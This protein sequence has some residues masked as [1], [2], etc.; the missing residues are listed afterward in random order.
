MDNINYKL[1]RKDLL[2]K[3]GT[4]GIMLLVMVV[5]NA[6]DKEL[7]KYANDYKLN[8]SDYIKN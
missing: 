1:L 5:E 4:S 7:L 8:I 3:V 2:N 6:S